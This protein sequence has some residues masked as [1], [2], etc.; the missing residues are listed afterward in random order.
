M[1]VCRVHRINL[2][3]HH[4]K[5]ICSLLN[6]LLK[7]LIIKSDIM[8]HFPS[9]AQPCH[10]INFHIIA[11]FPSWLG[12][13]PNLHFDKLSNKASCREWNGDS[14]EIILN[15]RPLY[16]WS[17]YVN[18]IAITLANPMSTQCRGSSIHSRLCT[19]FC[20]LV[21][22]STG[23]WTRQILFPKASFF[24]AWFLIPKMVSE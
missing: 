23:S 13:T 1:F 18:N 3:L 19:H 24:T 5:L 16:I 7:L 8:C 12:P 14:C 2:F 9:E 4:R 17:I 21:R 6:G 10:H 22:L 20:I 11:L 15:V